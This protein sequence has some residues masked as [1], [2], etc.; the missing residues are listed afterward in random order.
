M[1]N[2]LETIINT[3]NINDVQKQHLYIWELTEQKRAIAFNITS[4]NVEEIVN[5]KLEIFFHLLENN[6]INFQKFSLETLWKLW[7]NLGLQLA[8]LKSNS[9]KPLIQG[10]LGGQ[11]TGKSTLASILKLILKYLGY[12]TESLS[13]DDLY[14]TYTERQE[15]M[16]KDSRLNRRGP[17]GTH[18]INLGLETINQVINKTLPLKL[19][20][21][22]KSLHQGAGD[23]IEP[24]IIESSIDILL[25]EGWFV[26]IRPINPEVFNHPPAPIL[27]AKDT[28]FAIDMNQRLND[29][30]KLWDKLDRLMILYPEDYRLSLIWRNEAEKEMIATGK[31]G[32]SAS[33]IKEFV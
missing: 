21:F 16:L 1:L 13:L 9:E 18:D 3:K 17:P 25:F 4:D 30:V 6:V 28:Q 29:Y 31:T 26:G 7:L 8:Q 15:L 32:M 12:H 33:Q 10:I 2:I 11:G 27:T 5:Q 14:L 20:R 24:L 19:P 22:D 23:R